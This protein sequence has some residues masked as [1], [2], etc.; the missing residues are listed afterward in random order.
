MHGQ[1]DLEVVSKFNQKTIRMFN[2]HKFVNKNFIV[3]K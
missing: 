2:L 3:N 1:F